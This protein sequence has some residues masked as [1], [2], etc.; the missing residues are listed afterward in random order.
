MN[1]KLELNFTCFSRKNTVKEIGC[2]NQ[3]NKFEMTDIK[4]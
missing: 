4:G 1:G 2:R 3:E